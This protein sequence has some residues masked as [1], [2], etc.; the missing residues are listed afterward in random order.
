[1]APAPPAQPLRGAT[2]V[3]ESA[4]GRV[5]RTL[6]LGHE[7]RDEK[8]VTYGK[9]LSK[10]RRA[11]NCDCS[12]ERSPSSRLRCVAAITASSSAER[13]PCSSSTRS[14]AAVVPPGEVTIARS[15]GR[16]AA[17]GEQRGRADEQLRDQ[18]L[19]DRPGQPGEHAGVDQRLGD[20]EQVGRAATRP[21]RSRRRAG[22]SGTRTTVPTAPRM[23][24][25]QSRSSS[26]ADAPAADRRRALADERRRVRHRAHDGDAVAGCAP[27][28]W[29][30]TRR[31]RSTAPGVAP[32]ATAAATAAGDV[33][34]LHRDDGR[35]ARRD[36]RR[37]PSTPGNSLARARSR[38]A[39]TTSTTASSA[40]VGP[41]RRRAARRAAPHPCCRRRRSPAVS[42]MAA[43]TTTAARRD[44]V[45]RRV[46]GFVFPDPAAHPAPTM[47][48]SRSTLRETRAD[49]ASSRT[50]SRQFGSRGSHD[51]RQ[52]KRLA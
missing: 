15:C 3:D 49:V 12:V 22:C 24:S 19:G 43:N 37:R 14:P 41:A 48:S 35:V 32:A 42:V 34:R 26:V 21:G 1:M 13:S 2:P 31:R 23:P 4:G 8:R 52:A 39:S 10:I 40:G 6:R 50:P 18:R 29:R 7:V 45:A 11:S 9:L 5:D 47:R 27:R 36:R 46:S 44:G 16:V 33:G 25:A 30:S 38:R 20:Q 17:L 28:A 51:G